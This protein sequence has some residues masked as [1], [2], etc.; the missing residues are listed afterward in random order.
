[1]RLKK[2]AGDCDDG[3]C[4]G[5]FLSDRNTLVLQGDAVLKAEGLRLS[6]GEQAVELSVELVKEALRAL[7][8]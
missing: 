6:S 2:L 7:K 1:M 4:P 3:T 8:L 5:V